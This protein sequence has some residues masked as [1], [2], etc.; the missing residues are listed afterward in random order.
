MDPVVIFA[1]LAI[2]FALLNLILWV[3][4]WKGLSGDTGKS[5]KYIRDLNEKNS[6]IEDQLWGVIDRIKELEKKIASPGSNGSEYIKKEIEKLGLLNK[7]VGFLSQKNSQQLDVISENL[8]NL[9]TAF[10]K[11]DKLSDTM[12]TISE[13]ITRLS[14]KTKNEEDE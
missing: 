10:E 7:K 1:M 11:F 14:K 2:L 6:R 5:G 3:F 8:D 9:K 4:A 13:K 12:G